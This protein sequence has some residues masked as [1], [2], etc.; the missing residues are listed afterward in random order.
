MRSYFPV[1]NPL[2]LIVLSFGLLM[3]VPLAVSLHMLDGAATAYDEAI[4]VT[5]GFGVVLWFATRSR[6][7]DLRVRDGFLLVAL[8]C[9]LLPLIAALPLRL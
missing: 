4:A 1:L 2:G 7:R 6:K 8:T 5:L 9:M 3:A